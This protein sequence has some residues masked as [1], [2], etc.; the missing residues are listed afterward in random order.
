MANAKVEDWSFYG[1]SVDSTLYNTENYA[2]FSRPEHNT[3][4]TPDTRNLMVL[5]SPLFIPDSGYTELSFWRVFNLGTDDSSLVEIST[6]YGSSWLPIVS[7]VDSNSVDYWEFC[8]LSSFA[9]DSILIRFRYVCRAD[10][11]DTLMPEGMYIDDISLVNY[12][13]DTLFSDIADTCYDVTGLSDVD[14]MYRARARDN[15]SNLGEW[16]NPVIATYISGVVEARLPRPYE[17]TLYQNFPNPFTIKT[18]IRYTI[19]KSTQ[20]SLKIYDI[21]GR[22]VETLVNS[23]IL[24]GYHTATWDSKEVASGIYFVRME[25]GDYKQTRKIILVQ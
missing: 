13:N 24:P 18:T 6:N 22:L 21:T 8:N 2:Y 1:F 19:P 5:N 20:V 3:Y 16:S 7:Y 14:Y 23:K 10:T 11:M 17:F 12:M 15:L 4:F 25:A 9:G